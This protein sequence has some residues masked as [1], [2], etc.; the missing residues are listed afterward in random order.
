MFRI[1]S[2]L[3]LMPLASVLWAQPGGRQVLKSHDGLF[4]EEATALAQ[5]SVPVFDGPYKLFYRGSLVEQGS[6]E[7][8][9]RVGLW[10]FRNYHG[11]AELRYDYDAERPV[12][13]LPHEGKVY[14]KSQYPCVFLGSPIVPYYFILCNVFYPQSEGNNKAGGKVILSIMVDSRGH[15]TGYRVKEAS[16]ENFADAVR[17]AADSIPVAQWRWVPARK[18]GKN[19]PGVYDMTIFFDN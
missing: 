8:G 13:M 5:D 19:V 15:M 7:R 1:F 17:R 16:S 12:Y 14:S 4:Y 9:N 18:A 6:Y 11:I 3:L 2:L 10:E